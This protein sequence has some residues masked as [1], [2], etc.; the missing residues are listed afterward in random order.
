MGLMVAAALSLSVSIPV[1]A[2]TP[3]PGFAA[4]ASVLNGAAADPNCAEPAS[5]C[6]QARWTAYR[7]YAGDGPQGGGGAAPDEPAPAPEPDRPKER[8]LPFLGDLA[9]ERGYDLP[10]P[11]GAGGVYY[12]LSRDVDVTDVRVGRNGAPPTSG[13]PP[14]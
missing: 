7:P 10:L 2:V 9:R 14:G 8:T 6:G 5:T 3:T 13:S 4:S 12:F 11:L 1:T